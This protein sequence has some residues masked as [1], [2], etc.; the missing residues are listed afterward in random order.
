[1]R[2]VCVCV[3]ELPKRPL[4]RKKVKSLISCRV[5]RLKN[6]LSLGPDCSLAIEALKLR[7]YDLIVYG[8]SLNFFKYRSK[9]WKLQIIMFFL[10]FFDSNGHFADKMNEALIHPEFMALSNT[11][12]ST[13][14]FQ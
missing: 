8:Q 7:L 5:K 12:P 3:C 2:C 4:L 10:T 6:N 9:Y 1:M 13:Q 14:R 11:E